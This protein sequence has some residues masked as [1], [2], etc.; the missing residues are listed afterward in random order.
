MG[1]MALEELLSLYLREKISEEQAVGHILQNM[2]K[3]QKSMEEQQREIERLRAF[4]GMERKYGDEG[5]R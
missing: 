1:T 4:V 3:M 5:E 2:L